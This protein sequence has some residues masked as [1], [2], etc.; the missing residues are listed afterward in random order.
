MIQLGLGHFELAMAILMGCIFYLRPSELLSLKP[1]HVIPPLPRAG[2]G[3]HQW[4]IVLHE[5]IDEQSRPSKTGVFDECLLLDLPKHEFLGAGLKALLS[6]R[7]M[8]GRLFPFA[9]RDLAAALQESGQR[10]GMQPPPLPYQLRHSGPSVD[11]ADG[12]R[13]LAAIKRRGRWRTDSSLRRYEKG[14]Q[15]T[16]S[17]RRLAPAARDFVVRASRDLPAVLAGRL[18]PYLP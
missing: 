10:L 16:R 15:L 9:P 11:F 17:L 14:A 8:C 6:S 5:G 1:E 18:R 12:S 2:P 13:G 3:H 4:A 7:H